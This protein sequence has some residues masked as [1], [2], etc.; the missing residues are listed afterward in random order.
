MSEKDTAKSDY[1]PIRKSKYCLVIF[2]TS[3]KSKGN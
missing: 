2:L 1:L 3:D